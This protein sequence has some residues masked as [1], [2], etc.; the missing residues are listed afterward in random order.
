MKEKKEGKMVASE[1]KKKSWKK[2]AGKKGEKR[3]TKKS[4]KRR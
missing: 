2:E 3:G 4:R 1:R